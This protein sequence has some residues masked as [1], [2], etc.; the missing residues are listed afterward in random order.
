MKQLLFL[1][2]LLLICSTSKAQTNI[3]TNTGFCAITVEQVCYLDVPPC[4]LTYTSGA[5]PVAGG[6]G[7]IAM[8]GTC[9]PGEETYFIVNVT[10][11]FCPQGVPTV[12]VAGDNAGAST[13]GTP[14][15]ID[16][17]LPLCEDCFVDGAGTAEY[18]P[19]TNWLEFKD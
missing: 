10:S 19:A 4:T 3:I 11:P 16:T 7:F 17:T 9:A 6:G 1:S 13:C 18:H 15:Q 14:L 5:L 2:F 8:P 12:T